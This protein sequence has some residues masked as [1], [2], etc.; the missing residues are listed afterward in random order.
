MRYIVDTNV[1]IYLFEGRQELLALKNDIANQIIIPV[2]TPVVFAEVLGW[3]QISEEK[4]QDIRRY[5]ASLE[6]LPINNNHWE[7][8]IT[9]RKQGIK[10]K[11]PD[12]L[13]AA[14]AKIADYPILTRNTS[15][16]SPLAIGL[17][18]PFE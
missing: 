3:E 17:K 2:L 10:K 5:F 6:M 1:W 9:W 7:Q 13:I 16:F 11:M 14:N 4:E 18:N 12:L 15:D 8:I